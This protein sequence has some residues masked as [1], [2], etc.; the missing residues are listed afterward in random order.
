MK[1]I[2]D[3]ILH[4]AEECLTLGQ[5]ERYE[6]RWLKTVYD[7]FRAAAGNLGK[8]EAD[9]LIYAKMYGMPPEKTSDTLKIRYW[10]TGRH[11]PANREQCVSFGKALELTEQEQLYLIQAYY[12]RSDC[13]FEA[14][15]KSELYLN[16][17]ELMK[18]LA[19]E[20]LD[21]VHPVIKLQL[22]RAGRNLEHS[23]RHLYY[24]DAKRYQE[25]GTLEET[26]VERHISSLNYESEFSQQ[27]KGLGE[28]SRRTM[29]R[30]L[31]IFGIPF[32]NRELLS[33]RLKAFGYLPLDEQHTQVDGSC[34]DRLLLGFLELYEKNCTGKGPE[35][36]SRWF[37]GAYRILDRFLEEQDSA[38]LRFL[39]FKALKDRH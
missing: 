30:H 13:V 27:M 38:S 18:E 9:Q 26:E 28:I 36:C 35:F 11:L 5:Q 39:Y 34:L 14:E 33:T 10:R 7:R 37:H 19:G 25:A 20:Y 15:Q 8:T 17:K 32:I 2:E 24:T 12:D 6:L 16:R 29:I 31:L 21:K 4:L 1:E 23:L 3:A 22:Y